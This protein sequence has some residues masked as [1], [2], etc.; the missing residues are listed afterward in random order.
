MPKSPP[1][2]RARDSKW[3]KDHPA[4]N[5]SNTRKWRAEHPKAAADHQ[6]IKRE[7]DSGDRSKPTKCQNCGRAGRLHAAHSPGTYGHPKV[8]WLCPEC[9]KRSE[10]A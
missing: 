3:K 6:K 9:H 5:A 8:K 10:W 2:K 7:V 4:E 1:E